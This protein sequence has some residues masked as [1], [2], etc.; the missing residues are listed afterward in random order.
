MKP[1]PPKRPIARRIVQRAYATQRGMFL[2]QQEAKMWSETKGWPV[3]VLCADDTAIEQMAKKVACELAYTDGNDW[4]E[5]PIIDVY[6]G[7]AWR[8][9]TALGLKQRKARK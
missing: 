5:Y 2:T 4:A 7:E 8:I 9:L 1:K 3:F 6:G